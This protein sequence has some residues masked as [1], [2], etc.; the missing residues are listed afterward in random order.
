MLEG[1]EDPRFIARRMVIL[2]S[3]DIGNADPQALVVATAAGAGGGP[4]RPAGVRAQPGAGG[5]LP[6]AGAEVE[7]LD[8]GDLGG[9]APRPRARREAPARLPARRALPG[10]EEARAAARATSI[11]TTSPDGVADQPLCAAGAAGRALLRADRARLR[12]GAARADRG[13]PPAAAATEPDAPQLE[14]PPGVSGGA[15]NQPGRLAGDAHQGQAGS[16][17]GSVHARARACRDGPHHHRDRARRQDPR[18]PA[19]RPD[20]GPRGATTWSTHS[21]GTTGSTPGRATTGSAATKAPTTSA[22]RPVTIASGP[23]TAAR[24]RGRRARSRRD[25]GRGRP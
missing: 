9:D 24:F 21:A 1:G 11:R 10:R 16:G 19:G 20:Q 25:L 3:E 23:A 5:G 18:V 8:D 22:A 14:I 13:D 2:A 4:R 12:G 6:G 17:G 15:I 7:R